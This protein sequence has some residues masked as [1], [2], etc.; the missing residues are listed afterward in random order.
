MTGVLL[1][2]STA[3]VFLLATSVP[4]TMMPHDAENHDDDQIDEL[5]M[6]MVMMIMTIITTMVISISI[7]LLLLFLGV[8]FLFVY[9]SGFS[10]P[11]SALRCWGTSHSSLFLTPTCCDNKPKP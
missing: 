2:S 11:L 6:M 9:S 1:C 3:V 5:L 8:L 7:F 4:A 10:Q